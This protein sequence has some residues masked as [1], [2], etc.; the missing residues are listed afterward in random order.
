MRG[1]LWFAVLVAVALP[2]ILAANSPLLAW[3]E[4]IYILAGFA[5]VLG[6]GALLFQ[7]LLAGGYLP[8]LEGLKGRRFHRWI[9][10]FLITTI[11]VHV[12]CLWVTSPPDVVDALTFT[13]PAPFSAWGVVAMWAAFAAALLAVLRRRLKWHPQAWRHRHAVLATVTSVCT[14]IHVL[15]IEGTMEPVSK[16]ILCALVLGATVLLWLGLFRRARR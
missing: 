1:F 14:V 4:P 5:G 11:V 10:L 12:A 9:G 7:P 3:R 8:S 6:L 15:L 2:I 16:A 13:S